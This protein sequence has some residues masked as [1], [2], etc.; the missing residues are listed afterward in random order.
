MLVLGDEN[1][2][3]ARYIPGAVPADDGGA[4]ILH[5]TLRVLKSAGRLYRRAH[6]PH[7]LV[8]NRIQALLRAPAM[9]SHRAIR[10]L[11]AALEL[12]GACFQRPSLRICDLACDFSRNGPSLSVMMP[13]TIARVTEAHKQLP[14]P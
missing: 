9:A 13:A 5:H 10:T 3:L 2:N 11:T 4:S 6:S 1:V 14:R 12:P 7:Q 8:R